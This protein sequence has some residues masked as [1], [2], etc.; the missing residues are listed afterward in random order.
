MNNNLTEVTQQKL[1]DGRSDAIEGNKQKRDSTGKV[2]TRSRSLFNYHA[3]QSSESPSFTAIS[4]SEIFM[5]Q[6]GF[7]GPQMS[8]GSCPRSIIS[9]VGIKK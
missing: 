7:G 6:N 5:I 1:S 4:A 3:C 8:Y 9:L 2:A